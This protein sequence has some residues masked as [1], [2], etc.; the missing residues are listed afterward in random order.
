MHDT[1]DLIRRARELANLYEQYSP[2]DTAQP[3]RLLVQ[4]ADELEHLHEE[5]KRL[6]ACVGTRLHPKTAPK[7]A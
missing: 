6:R 4:V 3:A 7:R 1:A 5:N 2:R